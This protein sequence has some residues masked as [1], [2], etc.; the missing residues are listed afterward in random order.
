[1]SKKLITFILLLLPALAQAQ[2][3]TVVTDY[4]QDYFR[5]PLNIPIILAG[6]FGE[7]RPGH[8]HSGMDIKTLGKEN[9]PVHAAADG[10]VCR[11]K[12]DKGGFG[13]AL[14]IMHPNGYTTLYAH[15][16]K[17]APAIQQYMEDQQYDKK[18]WDVDLQLSP[19]QFPVKKGEQIAWS[20]NTG[21]STAPHLHF[22]IRNTQTEHPL[23]P[24]LFG[25]QVVDKIP[26]VPV[27]LA[28][29]NLSASIYEQEPN[30]ATLKKNGDNYTIGKSTAQGY[31]F[32]NDTVFADPGTTGIGLNIDDFM[33]GS[34]NTISFLTIQLYM[35]DSLQS[36][37]KLD[38]IGY[39][40]TRY[41]N[42]Y[43]DYKTRTQQRKWIQ[44]LFKLPGNHLDNIYSYLNN[45][46]GGLN[47]T[48]NAAH[49][50]K[51]LIT[52]DR[53]NTSTVSFFIRA[54]SRPPRP[55]I[56]NG[57]QK[58]SPGRENKFT[59]PNVMFTLDGKQ[60]YDD[61]NFTFDKTAAPNIYSDKYRLHYAY[62]PLHHYFDL[63]L[64]PNRPVPFDL[65]SKMVMMY[66]DDKDTDGRAVAIGESGWFKAKV[67][68]F[69]IYWLD[70]DTIPPAIKSMQKNNSNLAKAKQISFQVTDSITSVKTFSGYL[71]G[72]WL[73]FEQHGN[74]FFYNFDKHCPPGKHKVIFTAGDENGNTASTTLNFVR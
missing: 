31:A 33:D 64:K 23:N 44:L 17:F 50:V 39:D 68:N 70:I 38:N 48:D 56:G 59:H 66:S 71:D 65:Y 20:G 15:L 28:V 34:D 49:P 1:M 9:E 5:N 14:Y 3:N 27:E 29:Y 12:M 37:I 8:F 36:E 30:I 13:H 10:Y 61:I 63:Q 11:I 6:N 26:A 40:E 72:K 47:I 16:N 21:S 7:C 42:A 4:P 18:R 45:K 25:F 74:M 67:R 58:F 73:C 60:L 62:V 69:G 41:I 51:V 24:Q 43:T 55:D 35:D 52:D 53:N 2:N 32:T 19:T 46:R 57:E 22:E 54:A